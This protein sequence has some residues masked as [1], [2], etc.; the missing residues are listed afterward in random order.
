M[1]DR[2]L[3]LSFRAVC[4]QIVQDH[5]NCLTVV[6]SEGKRRPE[7]EVKFR[8]LVYEEYTKYRSHQRQKLVQLSDI[9]HLS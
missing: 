9:K 1:F 5:E 3:A 6:D 4:L 8:L 2:T 7:Q